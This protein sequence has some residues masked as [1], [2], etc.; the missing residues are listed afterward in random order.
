MRIISGRYKSRRLKVAPLEGVRPTSDKLRETIFNLLGDSVI[1][2]IF[3]DGCAGLGAIGIE[4]LSRGASKVYFV[5]RSRKACRAIRENLEALKIEAGYT[6]LEMDLSKA[7]ESFVRDNV[8]FD[9]AFLDPPYVRADL[10]ESALEKF[11]RKSLLAA[12]GVVIV[13]HSRRMSLVE[14]TGRLHQTRTLTQGDSTLALY[15]TE[16]A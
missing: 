5:D 4:A 9:I 2:S 11:G 8:V 3:L 16:E 15:R 1:D 6:I 13:E 10:Y 7:L 12:G 14:R